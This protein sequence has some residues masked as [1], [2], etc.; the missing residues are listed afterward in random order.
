[1]I[2]RLLVT[3]G[4]FMFGYF[5]GR[6]IGKTEHIRKRLDEERSS[7]ES[8]SGRQASPSGKTKARISKKAS[9]E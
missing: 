4:V 5:I 9:S 1:M 3:A 2:V 8:P 6:E 7:E